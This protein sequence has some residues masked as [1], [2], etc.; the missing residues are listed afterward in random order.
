MA[1]VS[2]AVSMMTA[3]APSGSTAPL[4]LPMRNERQR[5]LPAARMGIDTMVPSGTFCMAMPTDMASAAA[6]LMPMPPSAAPAR[7]TPTAMPSGRLWMVTASISMA[8]RERWERG[9]S[10]FVVPRW[11][12]GVA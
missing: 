6:V 12:W 7:T 4:R 5:L 3:S 9:P 2:H 8:V 11:R 10:G 1:G